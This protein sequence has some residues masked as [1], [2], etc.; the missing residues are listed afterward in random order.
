MDEITWEQLAKVYKRETGRS[1]MTRSMESVFEWAMSR[2]DL[3]KPS[4]DDGLIYIG[5]TKC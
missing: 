1:A 5:A 3:F 4:N 2:K